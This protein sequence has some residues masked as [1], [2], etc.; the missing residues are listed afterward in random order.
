MPVIL[1]FWVLFYFNRFKKKRAKKKNY[2][3]PSKIIRLTSI[4]ITLKKCQ[5]MNMQYP[6]QLIFLY[7]LEFRYNHEYFLY[8][9]NMYKKSTLIKIKQL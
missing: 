8:K 1:F 7:L 6:I 9:E 5:Q 3:L 2:I 4:V